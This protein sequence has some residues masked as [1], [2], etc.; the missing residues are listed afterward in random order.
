MNLPGEKDGEM[1]LII[2]MVLIITAGSDCS[3]AQLKNVI[4]VKNLGGNGSGYNETDSVSIERGR[5]YNG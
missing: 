5:I 2:L 4:E 3:H 1:Y